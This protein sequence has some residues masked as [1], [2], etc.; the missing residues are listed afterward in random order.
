MDSIEEIVEKSQEQIELDLAEQLIQKKLKYNLY[1][2][3]YYHNP[4]NNLCNRVICDICGR[5][6]NNQK[7][8]R[9]QKTKYCANHKI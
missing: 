2:V 5:E 6:V 8:K 4:D 1:M 3:N 7:L 9:H